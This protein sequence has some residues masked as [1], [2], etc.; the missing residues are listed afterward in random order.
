MPNSDDFCICLQQKI[1][2]EYTFQEFQKLLP[3]RQTKV[4]KDFGA[5]CG[6]DYNCQGF[7]ADLRIINKTT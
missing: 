7:A 4:Y 1:Q 2:R 6:N 5:S 3:I